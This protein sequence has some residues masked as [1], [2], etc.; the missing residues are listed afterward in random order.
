MRCTWAARRFSQ[1]PI[2]FLCLPFISGCCFT[3]RCQLEQIAKDWCETIRASQVLAVYPLTE[4][5]QP[6]DIFLVQTPVAEQHKSYGKR[7]FLPFDNHIARLDPAGYEVFYRNSFEVGGAG[8]QLPKFYLHPGAD[9]SQA[10]QGA[11]Q[12]GFPTYSVSVNR[13][14]GFTA[15]LPISG[16]PVGLSLLGS[17]AAN[18]TVTIDK[19]KTYGVDTLSLHAQVAMWASQPAVKAFLAYYA[20]QEQRR[21]H[22]YI[23]VI[24]RIYVTGRLITSMTAASEA[25]FGASA[26]APKPVDLLTLQPGEN[27][28]NVALKAYTDGLG[29]LNTALDE[30]LKKVLLDGT[31]KVLPGGSLKVVAASARSITVSEDFIDRPLVIGYLGFDY[32][33]LK[34]GVLGAPISTYAV[35]D[36]QENPSEAPFFT[37]EQ[38]QIVVLRKEIEKLPDADRRF[39]AAANW[40]GADFKADYSREKE[41]N[42]N[43]QNPAKAAF[44][45]AEL[46]YLAMESD[47]R[48]QRHFVVLMALQQAKELPNL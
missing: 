6:G 24:S 21:L 8:K 25:S 47:G 42:K 14:G 5:L 45:S 35:V 23:R 41:A 28:E 19:A 18:V 9:K 33:I 4:D 11:P 7:G 30:A 46:N 16:V 29:K 1:W 27:P 48:G 15:A 17:D 20:P 34:N 40:L 37:A 26:G 38:A 12:A 2:I 13:G 43:S 36:G 32:A 31:E 3:R 39:E 44:L 10:W 22:N